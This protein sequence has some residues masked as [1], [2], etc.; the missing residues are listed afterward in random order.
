MLIL[1]FPPLVRDQQD[2]ANHD[3]SVF[4][5]CDNFHL[6]IFNDIDT[7]ESRTY[8]T[9]RYAPV[10][11][12]TQSTFWDLIHKQYPQDHAP[13]MNVCRELLIAGMNRMGISQSELDNQLTISV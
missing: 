7:P 12:H 13:L 1:E 10:R 4:L 3:P 11:I 8:Y 6:R 9:M 5:T 2:D